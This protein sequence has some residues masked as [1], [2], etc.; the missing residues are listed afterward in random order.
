MADVS[1]KYHGAEIAAM[2]AT[3]SKV[4]TTGGKF[5][6]DDITIDYTFP[7]NVRTYTTTCANVA[8]I[9]FDLP[10]TTDWDTLECLID[11][12]DAGEAGIQKYIYS[13]AG[14]F[15]TFNAIVGADTINRSVS[16][17]LKYSIND[18]PLQGFIILESTYIRIYRPYTSAVFTL[19]TGY[20]LKLYK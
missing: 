11:S 20:A 5:C 6:D 15:G 10:S 4:L 7:S 19:G 1:I 2:S 18:T 9:Q 12:G 13:K 17:A 8:Y 16:N 14:D 3:G